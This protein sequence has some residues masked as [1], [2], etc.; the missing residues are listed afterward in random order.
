VIAGTNP[1]GEHI[2]EKRLYQ[3]GPAMAANRFGRSLQG[4]MTARVRE[5]P[6]GILFTNIEIL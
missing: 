4:Y 1:T 2:A 6:G 5:G 3:G